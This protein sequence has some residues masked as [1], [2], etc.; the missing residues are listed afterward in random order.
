MYEEEDDDLPLQYRRLTA[1]LQTSNPGFNARLSAYLTNNVAMRRALEQSIHDSYVQQNLNSQGQQYQ[2]LPL[3]PS[4]IMYAPQSPNVY[5]T[6]PY[7][8]RPPTQPQQPGQH[9][10]AAAGVTPQPDN[11]PS[12]PTSTIPASNMGSPTQRQ[13]PI[14][15]AGDSQPTPQAQAQAQQPAHQ[16]PSF[17]PGSFSQFSPQY[18]QSMQPAH[19]QS[20]GNSTFSNLP[21]TTA[22][23][24]NVQGLL[25]DTLDP[26]DPFTL[27]LMNGSGTLP[28]NFYS[29][30][31]QTE[32]PTATD[33]G[34]QQTHPSF[35][36]LT[37]TLAPAALDAPNLSMDYTSQYFNDAFKA[38]TTEPTPDGSPGAGDN[39]SAFFD[40]DAWDQPSSQ[41]SQ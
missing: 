11:G 16:K 6:A 27:Q 5:R 12:M 3:F 24:G 32:L 33:I 19:P 2:P 35:D 15:T 26:N 7:P 18:S 28:G 1:H 29:F 21:F 13:T 34:K 23:S 39:W 20:Y 30:G 41:A 37:S 31:D 36:G 25:G 38:G 14:S 40:V 22:L 9:L 10:Q 17:P 8:V 4:P